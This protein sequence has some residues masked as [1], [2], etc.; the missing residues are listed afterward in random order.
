MLAQHL[1][2]GEYRD[3]LVLLAEQH[4]T[5]AAKTGAV[6][7]AFGLARATYVLHMFSHAKFPIYDS[8]TQSGIHFLTQGQYRGQ[9]IQKTKKDDPDW[10]L[11]TF[12]MIVR[13]LQE[14]CAAR[15]LPSQRAIDKALFCYGKAAK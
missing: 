12:C 6:T 8:N 2:Q 7:A 10:Y 9:T 4:Y 5:K 3:F 13:D 15:D 14:A 1:S 11:E